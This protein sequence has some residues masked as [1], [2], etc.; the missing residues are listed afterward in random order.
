MLNNFPI[1]THARITHLSIKAFSQD[2]VYLL[3]LD[4]TVAFHKQQ[5][6]QDVGR[7]RDICFGQMMS[8]FLT[9][10]PSSQRMTTSLRESSCIYKS[11]EVVSTHLH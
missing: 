6:S 5:T 2:R 10:H 3:F 8:E 4:Q 7:Y 1:F 11:I 9:H